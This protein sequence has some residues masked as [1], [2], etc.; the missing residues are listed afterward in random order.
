MME[1]QV[2]MIYPSTRNTQ[3][4]TNKRHAYR[5][6]KRLNGKKSGGRRHYYVQRKHL[7][8]K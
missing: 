1:Q 3:E 5:E 2:W 6:C 7:K 4:F 8:H